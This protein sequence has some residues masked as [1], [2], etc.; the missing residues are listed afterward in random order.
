MLLCSADVGQMGTY[1][2]IDSMLKQIKDEGT[3]NIKGFLKHIHT[4][5]NFLVQTEVSA[6]AYPSISVVNPMNIYMSRDD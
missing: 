3:V 1:I 6:H 5:R 2:V 4:Q